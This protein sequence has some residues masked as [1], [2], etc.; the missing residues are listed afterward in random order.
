MNIK[1]FVSSGV[2]ALLGF[3]ALAT[4]CNRID[5]GHI[6]VVTH[7]GSVQQTVLDPGIAFTRPYPFAD[8]INVPTAVQATEHEAG[9]SS[10]DLQGVAT[11]ITVQWA[12]VSNRA[13]CLVQGFGY[14]EGAWTNGIMVPAIQEVVKSVSAQYTAE[15]L[16]KSRKIVKLGIEK[17]LESFVQKTL[18]EKGCNGAIKIANVAVTNFRFSQ[19]FDKAIE[20][21]VMAEQDAL[22]ALNEKT[23]RIT[24]AEAAYQE[25]KLSSDAI[26]YKTEVESKS[27]ADAITRESKAL[28]TNPNLVQ[29]RIA[30]RWDGKLPVYTGGGMPLMQMP[31]QK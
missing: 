22:K 25:Q 15:H 16:I 27:R 30:E 11:S 2:A 28:E 1:F 29:L 31:V 4:S 26:A 5:T 17:E 24:Q 10:S 3:V 19:E 20:A 8:V 13:P 7:F 12:I 9:A 21:K 23:R 6:G 14:G 18:S